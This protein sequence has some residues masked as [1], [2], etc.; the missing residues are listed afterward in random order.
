MK[1]F[2]LALA[3]AVF[4]LVGGASAGQ[5]LS[6]GGGA[7]RVI[8]V[9]KSY[10]GV[11]YKAGGT[12]EAG[13]DCSGFTANV[14]SKASGVMLPRRA[15]DQANGVGFLQV[16][17]VDVRPGDLVFFRILGRKH[18]HVGI[19]VGAGQFIHAPSSGGKVRF[20]DLHQTYW[21]QRLSGARRIV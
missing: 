16:A 7:E 15:E 13:F 9:A 14:F 19:Y 3:L 4:A 20:D 1:V 12:D 21:D 18:S 2:Q 10:L 17:R 6:S 8:E 5:S 11:E